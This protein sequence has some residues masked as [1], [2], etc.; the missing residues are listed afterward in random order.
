MNRNLA[1]LGA[2]IELARRE[3]FFYAQFA[4]SRR[5]LTLYIVEWIKNAY[6]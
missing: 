4:T 6:N 5:F 1:R 2:K 3:F